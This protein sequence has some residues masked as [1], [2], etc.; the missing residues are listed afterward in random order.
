[1]IHHNDFLKSLFEVSAIVLLIR[2]LAAVFIILTFFT[3]GPK[4]IHSAD[5]GALIL[6]GLLPILFS[7]FIFA[8]LLLPLLLNF[9]LLELL[10]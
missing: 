5:T 2:M 8:G 10:G 3:L 9:G 1:M 6:N 4:A 7:I